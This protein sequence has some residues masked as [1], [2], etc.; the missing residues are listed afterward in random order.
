MTTRFNRC[1]QSCS[2]KINAE[3]VFLKSKK[4]YYINSRKILR[5]P[6]ETKTDISLSEKKNIY[7][8][9]TSHY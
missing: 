7:F 3:H 4:V 1:E 5:F 9:V 8:T 6:S 2:E